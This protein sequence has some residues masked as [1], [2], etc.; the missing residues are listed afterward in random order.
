MSAPEAIRDLRA[1]IARLD[2]STINAEIFSLR[3]ELADLDTKAESVRT[4]VARL[5]REIAEHRGPA[6]EDVAAAVM[7]GTDPAEAVCLAPTRQQVEQRR[8]ALAASLRPIGARRD[9]LRHKLDQ[10]E[11]RALSVIGSAVRPYLAHLHD[12]QRAAA[13]ELVTCDSAVQ[14]ISRGLRLH[15]DHE[16]ASERAREAVMGERSLLGWQASLETPSDLLDALRPLV[17]RCAA[18]RGIPSA[19]PTR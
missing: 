6:A 10:A 11:G 1:A 5:Q 7:A 17:D 9:D 12:R 16:T 18:V 15:V 4:E 3:T 2:F 19:I 8:D 14:A 13:Q